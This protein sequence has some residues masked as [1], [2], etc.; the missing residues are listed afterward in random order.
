[1]GSSLFRGVLFVW[2][3]RF[4]LRAVRLLVSTTREYTERKRTKTLTGQRSTHHQTGCFG[5][6]RLR[7]LIHSS[8]SGLRAGGISDAHVV[9]KPD[10]CLENSR[11]SARAP[12]F[13]RLPNAYTRP[14]VDRVHVRPYYHRCSSVVGKPN[15]SNHVQ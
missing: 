5:S 4:W 13:W 2:G 11:S 10:G 9:H 1:M 12:R 6:T 8:A 15:L 14:R 3:R 7:S